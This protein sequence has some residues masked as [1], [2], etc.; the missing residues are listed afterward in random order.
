MQSH[1]VS[2]IYERGR[3]VAARSAAAA[4]G[5]R[6]S[7]IS[8][9][10]TRAITAA[11]TSKVIAYPN[12]PIKNPAI[13][14]PA[15]SPTSQMVPNTPMA[16]P[17]RRAEARSAMSALV[18]GVTAPTP[19]PSSGAAKRKKARPSLRKINGSAAAQSRRPTMMTGVRPTR[20]RD[21]SGYRLRHHGQ[22]QL[23]AENDRD[24][25]IVEPY[26]FGVD[27]QETEKR[28]VAEVHDGLD[29]G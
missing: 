20:S 29:A 5:S 8:P 10:V 12:P 17:R 16:A 15:A 28:P 23:C 26:F 4:F 1:H 18:T 14:G 27:R 9:T 7:A 24:L 22:D 19:T 13:I 2:S 3:W 6:T 21:A 11:S 25:G